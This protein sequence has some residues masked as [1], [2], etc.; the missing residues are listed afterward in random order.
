MAVTYTLI[1]S[2]TVSGSSTSTFTFSSIPSSY[3]HLILNMSSRANYSG[4]YHLNNF[5]QVNSQ[6]TVSNYTGRFGY[7]DTSNTN[8]FLV[9]STSPTAIWIGT[10]NISTDFFSNNW[11]FIGNYNSSS[12]PS[13]RPYFGGSEPASNSLIIF[14]SARQG[15]AAAITSLTLK[16]LSGNNYIAGST[17]Y[18]YGLK[19]S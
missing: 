1:A 11:S 5:V 10:G 6:S 2:Y 4:D 13:V 19:N 14:G 9:Q 7:N 15:T 18:L 17:F 8:N 3:D 12:A 16:E